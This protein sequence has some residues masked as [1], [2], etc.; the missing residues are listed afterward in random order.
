MININIDKTKILFIIC[1]IF[2]L[3]QI[4]IIININS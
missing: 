2:H 4:H 1:I 3:H